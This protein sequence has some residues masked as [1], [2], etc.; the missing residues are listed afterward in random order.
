MRSILY[1]LPPLTSWTTFFLL[2]YSHD[3]NYGSELSYQVNNDSG[4]KFSQQLNDQYDQSTSLQ[5]HAVYF[6]RKL[7]L[8][9]A[10]LP[11]DKCIPEEYEGE[12]WKWG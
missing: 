4:G 6:L 1:A 9:K 5:R 12:T 10:R 7:N 2:P 8:F 3:S 11:L